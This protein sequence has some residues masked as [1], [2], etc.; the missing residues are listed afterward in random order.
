[1]INPIPAPTV[2]APSRWNS[3]LSYSAL[4]AA[5][6]NG[7][8]SVTA[9][10]VRAMGLARQLADSP[11][12]LAE[13]IPPSQ[14]SAARSSQKGRYAPWLKKAL[15]KMHHAEALWQKH[16]PDTAQPPKAPQLHSVHLAKK[17]SQ[18]KS[19]LHR[20]VVPSIPAV[21]AEPSLAEPVTTIWTAARDGNVA[22]VRRLLDADKMKVFSHNEMDGGKTILHI[23]CWHGHVQ[24]VMFVTMFVQA[25]YGLD[26]LSTY[27]NAIDTAYMRSTALLD[28]CRSLKGDVNAKLQILK[29]LVQFGATVEHQDAHGDNALHWSARMQAVPTVR[30]LI[31]DTDAA[32][33]AFISENHKR[34]K[35]LDVAKL[36]RD[37]KPCMATNAIYDLLRRVYKDCNIRL[38]I[39]YGKKLR[40]QAEAESRMRRMEDVAHAVDVARVLCLGADQMWTTAMDTAETVRNDLEAKVLD[41]GGKEAVGRAQLWLETKEGKAWIKNEQPEAVDAIKTLVQKGMIPKPR[42]LKKAAVV[43]LCESYVAHQEADMRDLIKKKFGRDHPSF[44]S[45]DVEY[46]KR[47]VHAVAR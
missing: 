45:R 23:A 6:V 19:I 41:E 37:A 30:Y 42:D 17:G 7:D 1:M 10:E 4:H 46:Y 15:G 43:R 21:D 33:Y 12:P 36:A 24:V 38:K 3:A 34:Q 20:V 47:L 28:T 35:P 16:R 25:T 14:P 8:H 26:A 11:P 39:Q 13:T 40:L 5:D 32:V 22:E 9:A 2:V 29:L 18:T 31:Q 27:V 44:E